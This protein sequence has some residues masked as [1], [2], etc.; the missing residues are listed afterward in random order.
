MKVRLKLRPREVDGVACAV[1]VATL[2][3][4]DRYGILVPVPFRVDTQADFTAVPVAV[5]QEAR[6]PFSREHPTTAIGLVG[7][8]TGYRDRIRIV[9]AGREHDWP[10]DFVNVRPSREAGR[11]RAGLLPTLGR[12]GFLNEYA[13]A[14]DS[15]YL[16]I[17]RLGPLRCRLRR[18]LHALWKRLGMVHPEGRPL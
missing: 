9:V 12:A 14:V 6:I 18:W 17:A 10:C 11:Q 7:E 16:I 3:V 15:G 4:R 8:T 2:L 13:I 5:A 1:P